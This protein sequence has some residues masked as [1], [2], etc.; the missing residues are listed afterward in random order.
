MAKYV[1]AVSPGEI[2][3]SAASAKIS[4]IGGRRREKMAAHQS[5]MAK[6]SVSISISENE[7][8]KI[9]MWHQHQRRNEIS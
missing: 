2:S 3:S 8:S 4:E 5:T 6:I 9:M 1:A 7:A